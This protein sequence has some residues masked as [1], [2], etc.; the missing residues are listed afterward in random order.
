MAIFKITPAKSVFNDLAP[1]PGIDPNAFDSDSAGADTLIVNPGAF[2]ISRFGNGAFLAPTG[3]WT[4]AVNGSVIS[5]TNVGLLL[6][7]GNTTVSTI[8]IGV[9]GGVQGGLQGIQLASAGNVNNAGLISSSGGIA[10]GSLGFQNDT[11]INSGQIIGFVDL[12]GGDD[13]VTNFVMIGDVM[14]SGTITGTIY[15]GVGNDKFFGGNNAERVNDDDGADSYTFGGGNDIYIATGL[16]GADLNDIIRGGAGIDT[17]DASAANDVRINLD[18]VAHDLNGFVPVAAN[19][20]I[21]PAISGGFAKDSIFGFENANGGAG[22]DFIYG[23][24]GANVLSGGAGVNNLLGFGGNDTL[25]GGAGLD[26]LN[27]GAGKDQLTGGAGQDSF[28]YTA[29]SDSGIT[30]S[31]RDLIADFEQGID[32]IDLSFIDANKTNAAGT[33]DGFNFIGTNVPFTGTPGQLHSSSMPKP[34]PACRQRKSGRPKARLALA[35]ATPFLNS[36]HVQL[37][38]LAADSQPD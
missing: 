15:L 10:I 3:A 17:Y 26:G 30:A 29:L 37:A 9:D 27:G 23:T 13:K 4:V 24:A 20:A 12:S 6:A 34:E 7:G 22:N 36:R 21:G 31:A 19:T 1:L 5:Q 32:H 28:V 14:K 18:T 2:L 11:V 35:S 33:N 16:S 38:Q 25:N 8:K